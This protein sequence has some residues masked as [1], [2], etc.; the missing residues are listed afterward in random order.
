[1]D[2]WSDAPVF[3]RS[4]DAR[5]VK[6][7]PSAYAVI[8]DASGCVAIV[9]SP[10]GVFLVGGGIEPGET[11]AE[12]VMREAREEC[13][14][15]VRVGVCIARAVQHADSVAEATQFEKRSTFFEATIMD[16][17]AC[18][19]EPGHELCWV[20]P[21]VAPALLAHPSHGWAVRRWS[22]RPQSRYGESPSV[23]P[24]SD[25]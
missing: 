11:P 2:D 21:A 5:P 9:K 16:D 4:D 20:D 13:G 10:D 3:G 23:S 19:A 24:N 25:H 14:F 7:R 22:E 15:T 8:A 1:M 18:V 6:V 17:S 12:A